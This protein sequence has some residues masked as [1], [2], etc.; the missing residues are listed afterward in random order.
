MV[1][2]L[3][4]LGARGDHL[5]LGGSNDSPVNVNQLDPRY[6]AL[7]SRLFELVPNPFFAVGLTGLPTAGPCRAGDPHGSCVQLRQLLRPFPQFGDVNARQISDGRSRYHAGVIELQ[8][9]VSR[10]WGVR[11]SY[12]YSRLKDNQ[13]GETTLYS[14]VVGLPINHYDLDAEYGLSI[15]DIP[16][17]AVIA[18]IVELPFGFGRAWLNESR[19][20]DAFLGG[21]TLA[22]LV[23]LES[24]FPINVT[25]QDNTGTFSGSQRPNLNPGVDPRTPGDFAA[26]LTSATNPAGMWINPAAFSLAPAFTFGNAPRTLPNLRTPRR[27][28]V[29]VS[30]AKDV[31]LGGGAKGT[32]RVE[33]L[34]LTNSVKVFGPGQTLGTGTFGRITQQAGFPRTTQVTMRVTF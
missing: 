18:P 19:W 32:L 7:G 8:R 27:T 3:S 16:H 14:R 17:R 2:T 31:R 11:A 25:Q 4:Y 26:R 10:G 33:I 15:I 24:G 22:T 5:S 30:F 1:V 20:A 13:Y 29:D 23:T 28:N 9:A 21:W 6:M 12:T 34:N